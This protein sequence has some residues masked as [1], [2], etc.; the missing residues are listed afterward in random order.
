M[1]RIFVYTDFGDVYLDTL[2]TRSLHLDAKDG[3][4]FFSNFAFPKSVSTV[5][6]TF[7]LETIR[8]D[9]QLQNIDMQEQ[10]GAEIEVSTLSGSFFIHD[11]HLHPAKWLQLDTTQGNVAVSNF[12]GSIDGNNRAGNVNLAIP[13]RTNPPVLTIY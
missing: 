10:S 12:F 9:V 5:G 6:S 3:S 4:I 1:E 8:G 2:L 13:V 7:I 11:V